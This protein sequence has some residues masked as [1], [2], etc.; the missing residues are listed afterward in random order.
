MIYIEK[1]GVITKRKKREIEKKAKKN[2]SYNQV[3]VYIYPNSIFKN[4]S[5]CFFAF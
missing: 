4:L 1:L 5:A 3:Y 2:Q